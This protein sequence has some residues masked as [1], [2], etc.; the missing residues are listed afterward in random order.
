MKLDILA[1]AAHPDDIEL[2]CSGTLASLIR[3][4]KKAGVL[5][6]T[7]GEF[8]T[9]GTPEQRMQEAADAARVLGLSVREN[10]GLPDCGLENSAAYREIIIRCVRRY[11][12]DICFLNSPEDRHPD[13]RNA[14][15][16]ALDALF[17]SGLEKITTYDEAGPSQNIIYINPPDSQREKTSLHSHSDATQQDEYSGDSA[18]S[19]T[20]PDTTTSDRNTIRQKP[21]RPYHILHYMQ[22]WPFKPDLIFDITET[23]KIREKAIRSFSSQFDVDKDRQEKKETYVSTKRF[24]D[25]VEGRAREYGQQIGVAFGEPFLYH[26]KPIPVRDLDFLF[27]NKT[28]S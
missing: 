11:R 14:A 6:L 15:R 13:H 20:F 1:I 23:I 17:Y 22:H 27:S 21:W 16:L 19:N 8:G 9:L 18:G 25:A 2:S 12:P 5:D 7:K 10:A 3:S 28:P 4:G 24:F 26:G